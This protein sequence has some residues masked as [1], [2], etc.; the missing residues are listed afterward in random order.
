MHHLTHDP[1]LFVV[2][3]AQYS[4]SIRALRFTLYED[5]AVVNCAGRLYAA[6]GGQGGA[7]KYEEG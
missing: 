2:R 7:G 1:K 5:V 4:A 6:A 3:L